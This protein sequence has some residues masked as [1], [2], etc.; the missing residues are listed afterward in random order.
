M[1][2]LKNRQEAILAKL[3]GLKNQITALREQLKQPAVLSV[4]DGTDVSFSRTCSILQVCFL[5]HT[6]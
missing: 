1:T 2:A 3:A 6:Q 4:T 5:L